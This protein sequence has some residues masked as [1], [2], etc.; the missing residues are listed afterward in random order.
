MRSCGATGA[1]VWGV[2]DEEWG[3]VLVGAVTLGP[4]VTI[5]SVLDKMRSRVAP[6]RVPKRLWSVDEFPLLPNQ[7]IDRRTVRAT[8]FPFL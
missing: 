7:K 5:S 2:E 1:V 4:E 8:P 6:H 3:Q